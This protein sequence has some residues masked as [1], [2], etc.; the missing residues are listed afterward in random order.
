MVVE[1]CI[2]IHGG[3]LGHVREALPGRPGG[4]IAGVSTIRQM[5]V[6][7]TWTTALWLAAFALGMVNS[8]VTGGF[9]VLVALFLAFRNDRG[10]I[11]AAWLC[12]FAC[13]WFGQALLRW[14]SNG[15]SNPWLPWLVLG[16]FALFASPL[17]VVLVVQARG[18]SLRPRR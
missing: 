10:S 14:A 16:I 7:R 2:L 18:L 5:S 13:T 17:L 15:D 12:G 1:G 8:M 6:A 11:M 9:L 4:Q 3:S